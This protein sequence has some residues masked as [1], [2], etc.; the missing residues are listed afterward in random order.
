MF[1]LKKELLKQGDIILTCSNE[2]PSKAIC[3]LTG[4]KYS[5]AIL[6]VGDSSYI[7]SDLN[8]VHSGNIQRLIIDEPNFVKVIR[9]KD[10]SAINK[11]IEYAR[12]QIG[13]SYSKVSAL[14]AGAKIFSKLDTK[15]QFCS[16]LVAKSYE[17]AGINLVAN[18]DACLPQ[19]ISDS[20][21]V[22]TVENCISVASEKETEFA[23]SFNPIQ[24]QSEITNSI[25]ESVRKLI[26]NKIQALADITSHL[27]ENPR[28]D[29]EV[30]E[31]Y[32]ISG[33]LDIWRYEREQNPW[34]YDENLFANL[35]LTKED[36]KNCALKE[37]GIAE[38]LLQLYK[39]NLEQYFYI[40]EQHK[41]KYA[42]QQFALYKQL[43]ENTLDHKFAAEAVINKT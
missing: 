15:R 30:T 25:L 17:Y 1:L 41:L 36:M 43:V 42:E 26:G 14:N 2:K 10:Q 32:R 38:G 4:S 12:L 22:L 3:K 35:P 9:V 8:G 6:Y 28:F 5:H 19:E 20:E 7:H 21:F 33:Y 39:N 23:L 11:A 24:R 34:R 13:T 18:S 40:K 27:I 16:R 29:K 31:I 37:L